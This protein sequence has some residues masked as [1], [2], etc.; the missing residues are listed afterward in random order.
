MERV[1]EAEQYNLSKA[2]PGR[3]SSIVNIHNPSI[4]PGSFIYKISGVIA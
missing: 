1:R 4:G 3:I 2:A